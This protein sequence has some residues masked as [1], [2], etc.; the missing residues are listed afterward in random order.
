[1]E[2]TPM[3]DASIDNMILPGEILSTVLSHPIKLGPGL[4]HISPLQGEPVIQATQAG[5][6]QTTKQTEFYID[7]NSHRYIPNQGES[8]IGQILTR[9]TDT[10]RVDINSAHPATLPALS[11]EAATKQNR[12]QLNITQ[13]VYARVATA[14]KDIEP[15]IECVDPSSGKSAGYGELKGGLLVDGLS[16]QWCRRLMR[17]DSGSK[18]V[19]A[20]IGVYVGFQCA[21]GMNG[22]VWVDAGDIGKTILVTRVIK[23]AEGMSEDEVRKLIRELILKS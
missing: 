16:L 1:M 19:L 5:L 21:V 14:N 6:L 22:R 2:D 17:Q 15:E 23:E 13:L 18:G 10:Y 20:E 4:R 3:Q 7:Y 11:F 12:P 9:T 8:V